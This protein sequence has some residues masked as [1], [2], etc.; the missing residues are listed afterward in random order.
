MAELLVKGG[1]VVD[2]TGAPPVRADVR[3][4]DGRVVEV[5]PDLVAD[6][7]RVLD[8]SGA[9]VTPGLS[10]AL[11]AHLTPRRPR[12]LVAAIAERVSRGVRDAQKDRHRH[13]DRSV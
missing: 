3:V 10:N 11:T 2:G 9:Y 5:G 1:E 6:G 7:E 13:P 12:T 8:A 4:R